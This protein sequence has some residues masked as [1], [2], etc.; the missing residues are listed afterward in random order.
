ML[1]YNS[2][3]ESIAEISGNLRNL[4][5]RTT[6]SFLKEKFITVI[7][8]SAQGSYLD[9]CS[10]VLPGPRHSHLLLYWR[11]GKKQEFRELPPGKKFFL[12]YLLDQV[13]SSQAI[14]VQRSSCL[15]HRRMLW[16]V[17]GTCS[18]KFWVNNQYTHSFDVFM[19]SFM[20]VARWV[21]MQSV[22]E[23]IE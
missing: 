13:E 11:R 3:W 10:M 8:L 7:T 5:N 4:V 20:A 19:I 17:L 9:Q 2:C 18:N 16:N 23:L 21:E 15:I 12:F 1:L 6:F 14:S 22:L